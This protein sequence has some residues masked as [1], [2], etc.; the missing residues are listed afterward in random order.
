M[1]MTIFFNT[2]GWIATVLGILMFLP[3]SYKVLRSK[4]AEGLS[5]TTF[6]IAAFGT[7]LWLV[8]SSSTE[9]IPIQA[10]IA[11]I[12]II[13]LML[14]IVYHLYKSDKA[15]LIGMLIL[16]AAG[17]ALSIVWIV[18]YDNLVGVNENG[19][20]IH[21]VQTYGVPKWLNMLLV[22]VAGASTSFGYI[23]QIIKLVKSK[24]AGELSPALSLLNALSNVLWALFWGL[25]FPDTKHE[26]L[27]GRIISMT[28]SI[29]GLIIN[30]TLT[31]LYFHYK[32]KNGHTFGFFHF[33][34]S[35]RKYMCKCFRKDKN[36]Q[37][38]VAEEKEVETLDK[39]NE[40]SENKKLPKNKQG[41]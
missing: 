37:A 38:S 22:I 14:P 13:F 26:E 11:N 36:I 30:S 9:I 21:G 15:L 4:S 1:D 8:W 27:P 39:K 28:F 3:Q 5:K 10:Y 2:I 31:F 25:Q 6:T 12:V 35:I 40:K 23:P 7:V 29:S 32:S 18:P 34:D 33:R 16:F 41:A 19:D 24:N 20:V 17:V